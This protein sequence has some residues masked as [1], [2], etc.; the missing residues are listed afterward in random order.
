M[1]SYLIVATVSGRP[2]A[3]SPAASKGCM[4]MTPVDCASGLYHAYAS[5]LTG[6]KNVLKWIQKNDAELAE[7]DW[8][9][10]PQAKFL[11]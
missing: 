9:I 8:K 5:D 1:T 7:H 10:Q 6:C 2:Y 3:V 4:S 11:R